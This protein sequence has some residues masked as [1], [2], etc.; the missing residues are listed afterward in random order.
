MNKELQQKIFDRFNFIKKGLTYYDYMY[1]GIECDDG[2]YDLI[3]KLCEELEKLKFE[4][5]VTQVK[6][7]FGGLRFYVSTANQEQFDLIYNYEEKSFNICETC[8]K[9]GKLNR[10][11]WL[12][13]LCDVCLKNN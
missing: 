4:G 9:E 2:W 12:K 7:K 6:E 3:W 11:S 8:G 1:F 10:G 5:K 13:V